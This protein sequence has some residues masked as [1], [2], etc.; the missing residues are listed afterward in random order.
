MSCP[1][2]PRWWPL[3]L[4]ALIACGGQ[5][6]PEAGGPGRAAAADEGDLDVRVAEAIHADSV[7]PAEKQMC[8][9]GIPDGMCREV[10]RATFELRDVSA[11]ICR[12][13]SAAGDDP[14]RARQCGES[15]ALS[16]RADTTCS[17]C[18]GDMIRRP[19]HDLF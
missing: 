17:F 16:K 13:G 12:G 6:R 18:S 15:R 3:A 14:G 10:C 8:R 2:A 1:S 11:R 19:C 5:A 4:A 9:T 7:W